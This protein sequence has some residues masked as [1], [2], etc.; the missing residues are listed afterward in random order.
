[1][2]VESAATTTSVGQPILTINKIGPDRVYIGRPAAY[3]ITVTNSSDVPAKNAI[4]EDTIPDGVTGV[5]ATAGAKLSGLKLVW[6]FGT[7]EPNASKN[8]RINYTPTKAGTLINTATA[9]AYCAE[10]VASTMRTSV[11]G[12]PALSL[13]VVDVEDPVRTGTRATYVIRVENQ[14]SATATNIQIA[15]LLENNVEYISSAGAT[16]GSREGQTIRFFPLGSLAPKSKAAWRVVVEA[17]RPGDVRFKAVMNADQL[18][19][20]VEETESTLIYD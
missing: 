1:M 9:T 13:E 14:G 19:R 11:T 16:A 5:K 12:I 2:R 8:V 7:L 6:E 20:P 15:C 10:A 4:L 17:V 3:E 18:S